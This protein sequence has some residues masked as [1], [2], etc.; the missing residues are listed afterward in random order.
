MQGSAPETG[1]KVGSRT[2]QTVPEHLAG[3]R[4]QKLTPPGPARPPAMP[5]KR[6]RAQ[7]G[8]PSG[9]AVPLTT[10]CSGLAQKA[11]SAAPLG[12]QDLNFP[13]QGLNPHALRWKH[14]ILTTGSPGTSLAHTS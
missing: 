1:A 4:S 6:H 7:G 14:G 2:E 10:R 9:R 5:G 11:F 8:L 13:D 3:G 12:T